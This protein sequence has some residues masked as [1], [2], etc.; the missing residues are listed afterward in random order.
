VKKILVPHV[1]AGLGGRSSS[2]TRAG[3]KKGKT[4]EERVAA[5]DRTNDKKS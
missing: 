5:L 1:I 4:P 3:K 2:G